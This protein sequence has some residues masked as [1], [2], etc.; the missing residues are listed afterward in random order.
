M[1]IALKKKKKLSNPEL[2]HT[3]DIKSPFRENIFR[4]TS[5]TRIKVFPV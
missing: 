5:H 1:K 3:S 2:V 4:H